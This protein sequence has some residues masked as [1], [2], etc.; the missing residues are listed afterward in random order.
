V[1]RRL[2]AVVLD[3]ICCLLVVGLVVPDAR[4]P[5]PDY[6]WAT[7]VC[8]T[9]EVLVLTWLGGASFGQRAFRMRVV[10]LA[11]GR[12]GLG[13]V[14]TRTFL[15]VLLIPPLVWDRDGRGLHDRLAGTVL[16]R[17]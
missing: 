17:A 1:G 11:G 4:Y 15:L 5:S 6:S 8:F 13:R 14:A 3:W 10:T 12:A 7:L 16:V 9:L 2:A